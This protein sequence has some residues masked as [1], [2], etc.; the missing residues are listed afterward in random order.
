[1]LNMVKIVTYISCSNEWQYRKN[2]EIL[3]PFNLYT[4]NVL[5]NGIITEHRSNCENCFS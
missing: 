5:V 2:S 1:M 3:V 4:A